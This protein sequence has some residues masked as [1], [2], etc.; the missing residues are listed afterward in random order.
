MSALNHNILRIGLLGVAIRLLFILVFPGPDYYAGI[1]N[2]YVD[3]ATNIV[4]G[5]GI[6]IPSSIASLSRFRLVGVPPEL[7]PSASVQAVHRLK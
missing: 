1:S 6:T 5:R 2:S 3:V 7:S 4:E